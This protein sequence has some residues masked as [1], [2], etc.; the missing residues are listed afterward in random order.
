MGRVVMVVLLA[1]IFVD[2]FCFAI[3]DVDEDTPFGARAHERPQRLRDPAAL[4][5]HAAKITLLDLEF[6][7]RELLVLESDDPNGVRGVDEALGEKLEELT[8]ALE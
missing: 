4:A 3:D 8:R 6:D 2:F 1:G 5:D 7:H